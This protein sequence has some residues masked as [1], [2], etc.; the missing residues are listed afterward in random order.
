[1]VIR[2][3][4][5]LPISVRWPSCSEFCFC[6]S[7]DQQRSA[8]QV[9]GPLGTTALS[10]DNSA[11]HLGVSRGVGAVVCRRVV[12]ILDAEQP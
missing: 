4:T 5:N 1:M 9:P 2:S 8:P 3:A 12:H 6:V 11:A 10:T 7:A